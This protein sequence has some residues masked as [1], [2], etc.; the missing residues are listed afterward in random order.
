[1]K[2][3]VD[4]VYSVPKD[5][6]WK[7]LKSHVYGETVKLAIYKACVDMY[8]TRK[9]IWNTIPLLTKDGLFAIW[10]NYNNLSYILSFCEEQDLSYDVVLFC[11]SFIKGQEFKTV[12]S[13]AIPFVFVYKDYPEENLNTASKGSNIV[14]LVTDKPVDEIASKLVFTTKVK[15]VVMFIGDAV[16]MAPIVKN[17]CRHVVAFSNESIYVSALLNEG[18]VENEPEEL[19]SGKKN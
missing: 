2:G 11:G 14:Q 18:V 12:Y 13:A 3:D 10:C 4:V 8:V 5:L 16:A 1:M 9:T 6:A 17:L 19:W 7:Y 15:D